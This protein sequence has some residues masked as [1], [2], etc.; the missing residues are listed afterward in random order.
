MRHVI[1]KVALRT[2]KLIAVQVF[3]NRGDCLAQTT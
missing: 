1:D 2:A 3:S